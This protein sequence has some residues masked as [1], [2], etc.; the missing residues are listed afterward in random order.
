MLS[1]DTA[2]QA[3]LISDSLREELGLKVTTD[4]SITIRAVTDQTASCIGKTDFSL[5]S[6]ATV[7]NY[8]ITGALVVPLLTIKV[9]FHM[10]WIR[11]S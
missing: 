11:V 9:L 1:F 3:I 7:E 5:K 4:P 10:Q 8:E 2:S 6:L